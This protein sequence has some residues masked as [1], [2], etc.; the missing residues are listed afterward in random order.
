[1]GGTEYYFDGLDEMEQNL[2][3][4]IETDFPAEF[5]QLVIEIGQELQGLVKENTPVDTS[6]L[7][8][9]WKLGKIKKRGTE[10]VIEVYNN[11]EYVEPVEYGHRT[12]RRKKP[13]KNGR[14]KKRRMVKG[15]HM[16]EISLAAISVRLPNHL[17]NWLSDFLNSH[18]L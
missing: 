8:N 12:R 10:Y 4:A 14:Y 13:L 11:T 7:Q 17:R 15:A 18:D 9:T 16:M 1:M 2:A 3:K 6:L 5:K